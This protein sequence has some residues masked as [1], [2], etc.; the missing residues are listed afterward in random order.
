M[1]RDGSVAFLED[2]EL[3]WDTAAGSAKSC[4]SVRYDTVGNKTELDLKQIDVVSAK[5]LS[6][7]SD[8]KTK[9][10]W[11]LLMRLFKMADGLKPL[12]LLNAQQ[13]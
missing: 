11:F 4:L 1:Q 2:T 7:E 10:Q 12:T 13:V 8:G 3:C 5:G 9:H 6:F